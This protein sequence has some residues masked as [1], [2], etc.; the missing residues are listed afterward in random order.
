LF[1]SARSLHLSGQWALAV[2][3]YR[4]FL[5]IEA[6]NSG[7]VG[8]A[9]TYLAECEDRLREQDARQRLEDARQQSAELARSATPEQAQPVA[10]PA[11]PAAPPPRS[12][13][14]SATLWSGTAVGAVGA[15]W[16]AAATWQRQNFE[17][18]LQPGFDGGKVEGYATRAEAQAAGHA[19]AIQQNWAWAVLSAGATAAV[20][21]WLWPQAE[22]GAR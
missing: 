4:A 21:A 20:T 11:V 15:L 6:A 9:R 10:T 5:H 3:R 14:R 16:L 13:V 18:G 22:R 1:A 12:P 7:Y 8:R 19:L 2:V 17:T